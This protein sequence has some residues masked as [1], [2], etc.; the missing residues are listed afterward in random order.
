MKLY[1]IPNNLKVM[2]FYEGQR[3][4][5]NAL[6]PF[7]IEIYLFTQKKR[8]FFFGVRIV[9]M[10]VGRGV[11]LTD[12]LDS[13]TLEI[14]VFFPA[15]VVWENVLQKGLQVALDFSSEQKVKCGN[16]NLIKKLFSLTITKALSKQPQLI[17]KTLNCSSIKSFFTSN[18]YRNGRLSS[19][20]EKKINKK[21]LCRIV[22]TLKLRS[23]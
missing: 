4:N 10:S 12:P 11:C 21:I 9:W 15:V 23:L 17:H 18:H 8:V 5:N 3:G 7:V 13:F 19:D 22:N 20:R 2:A 16:D 1:E 6:F 14:L